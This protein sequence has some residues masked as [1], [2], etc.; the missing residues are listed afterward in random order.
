MNGF[1][2]F[3]DISYI[4]Q[5]SMCKNLC[6]CLRRPY[7]IVE[8]QN[9][10]EFWLKN[11]LDHRSNGG[12]RHAHAQTFL[13]IQEFDN[14]SAYFMCFLYTHSALNSFLLIT[15]IPFQTIFDRI[16]IACP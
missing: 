7:K 2:L 8:R 1:Y 13:Q 6:F 14:Y 12:E 10:E 15:Y 16:N 5:F 9:Y 3:L 11:Y 4:C